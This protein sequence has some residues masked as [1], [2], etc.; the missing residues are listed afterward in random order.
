MSLEAFRLID[1]SSAASLTFTGTPAVRLGD[2]SLLGEALDWS[3]M[4]LAAETT[5]IMET[6]NRATFEYLRT[7]K[8]FG[9]TLSE[10]GRESCRER[11]C[12]YVYI[13]VVGGLFKKIQKTNKKVTL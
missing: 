5:G 13:S 7:R 3:L 2:A 8:Q 11:V 6:L 10:I 9:T 4:G 12:Q 1:G